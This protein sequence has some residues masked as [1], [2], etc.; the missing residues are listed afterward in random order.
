LDV[1]AGKL[2][3]HVARKAAGE[4]NMNGNCLLVVGA[5]YP[6]EL[7][8]VR[9]IV[10]D[11]PLLV[12][13]IGAQ[14]GDVEAVVRSGRTRNGTGLLISSSRPILYARSGRDFDSAARDAAASLRD[15]IR[16]VA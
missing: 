5:T 12:P 9:E 2:Y 13:G 3:E 15:Q 7:A 11:L 4:W 6:A 16:S 10:G 8:T 1:G 14:G